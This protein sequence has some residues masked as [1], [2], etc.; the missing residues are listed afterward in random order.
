MLGF[1]SSCQAKCSLVERRMARL[2]PHTPRAVPSKGLQKRP[3]ESSILKEVL[4]PPP[5]GGMLY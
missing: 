1:L 3:R 4:K 2:L 5:V